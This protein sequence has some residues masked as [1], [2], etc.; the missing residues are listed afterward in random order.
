MTMGFAHIPRKPESKQSLGFQLSDRL[1]QILKL[2]CCPE[3]KVVVEEHLSCKSGSLTCI[4]SPSHFSLLSLQMKTSSQIHLTVVNCKD[5]IFLDGIKSYC[6]NLG[7]LSN[8]VVL[9]WQRANFKFF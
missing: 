6:Q 1:L 4:S 7:Y 9:G 2:Q 8:K 5:A 3:A